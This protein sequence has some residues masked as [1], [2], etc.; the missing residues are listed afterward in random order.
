M[1]RKHTHSIQRGVPHQSSLKTIFDIFNGK[2]D[3]KTK[4]CLCLYGVS[5]DRL[6]QNKLSSPFKLY[7]ESLST[8]P[9]P[10][11]LQCIWAGSCSQAH[12]RY[13]SQKTLIY[14]INTLLYLMSTCKH[15][16]TFWKGPKI[17]IDVLAFACNPSIEEVET[18][19]SHLSTAWAV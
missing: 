18:G 11:N 4:A 1:V 16:S 2:Q 15:S 5:L 19:Q 9:V 14:W 6:S 3:S 13:Y 8:A 12:H 7:A 10:R 17:K